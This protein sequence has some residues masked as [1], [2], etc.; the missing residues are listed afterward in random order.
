MSSAGERVALRRRT[1]VALTV[2]LL[3]LAL[4]L[5]L[6]LAGS[7][8][9][10]AHTNGIENDEKLAVTYSE[11]AACQAGEVLPA[12][13]SAIRLSLESG[14][15]PGVRLTVF[16]GS[17]LLT[18]GTVGSGWIGGSVTVP[19]RAVSHSVAS[20]RVCFTVGRT[21]ER[22]ALLGVSTSPAVAARD[23][24]GHAL[25]GR[26]GIEYLRQG[27]STWASLAGGVAKRMGFGRAPSGGWIVL[28]LIAMMG[29]VVAAGSWL[30]LKE[31]R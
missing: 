4:A 9:V 16:S 22:V 7:P 3:L 5:V 1:T 15:G 28:P 6:T 29:V 20:A 14:V 10:L 12:Q 13:T 23:S 8:L 30:V 11:A 18:S 27:H 31:L 25:A 26:I 17:R 21:G 19:V 2:G 24:E